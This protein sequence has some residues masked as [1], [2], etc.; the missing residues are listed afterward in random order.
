[1]LYKRGNT[2][3]FEFQFLGQR[4]RESSHSPSRTVARDAER[5]RRRGL[6]ENING[7][8]DKRRRPLLFSVAARE[9]LEW[10]KG[11]VKASTYRI[12][13][14]NLDHL[15]PVL[16]KLL[17]ADIN[18]RDVL[19]YQQRRAAEGAAGATI[20]R[21]IGTLRAILRK[22]RLWGLLQP[23]V[24]KQQERDDVGHALTQDEEARLFDAC[25]NSRSRCLYPAV[26]LG[27]HTGLRRSEL[28]N[29]RWGQID[30]A[31]RTIRVGDSKTRAGRGRVVP[32]NDRATAVASFWAEFFPAR[33]DNHAVFPTERV[34]AAGDALTPHVSDTDPLTPIGSLKKA[35]GTAKRVATVEV[36]WHDLR[37][38]CCTRLLE[39]GVS[40]P[41][42]GKILGWSA[43]T[44]VRMA[45][46]YG[47]IGQ[48]AQRQAMA[49]LD[50]PAEHDTQTPRNAETEARS[51]SA[52]H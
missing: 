12:E 46:R 20:N 22:H 28:L 38:S 29:L 34:G 5:Q 42:V 47:H 30:L 26:V 9:Y 49:L 50:R 35:W 23:D 36:R 6:E 52:I 11:D 19:A 3:W 27:L 4:V 21:E 7:L 31:S 48:G 33:E 44:T 15:S 24:K 2:W 8:R 13:S 14:K 40:L 17:L 1:M 37:H 16:G 41:I 32:L 51:L 39:Q 18:G 10:K 43:S 25:R 45:Q